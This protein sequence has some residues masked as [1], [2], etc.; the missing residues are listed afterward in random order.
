MD[1]EQLKFPTGE[2]QS[3]ETI[4]EKEILNWISSITTLPEKLSKIV[5]NLSYE[6]LDWIYRP[7]GWSI[8]QVVHHLADSHMN[9]FIRF[10]LA[11]TEENPTIRPYI[12]ER[13]AEM[14]DANNAEIASSL[15]ILDGVHERMT[16]LFESLSP[17]EW[18]TTFYHP[19]QGDKRLALDWM[20]GLYAWHSNHHLAHVE[21]AIKYEGTFELIEKE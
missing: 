3:P 14:P 9:S 18:K 19:E 16:L 5:T 4:S 8:K 1:L 13:W 15:H 21:Q 17:E 11:M 6:E 10:K 7:E 20:L 12:Q 2:Y